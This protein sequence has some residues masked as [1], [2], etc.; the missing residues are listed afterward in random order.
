MFR[1]SDIKIWVRLTASIWTLLIVVW[2]GTIFWDSH[3]NR[4]VAI[5]Q[6]VDFSLSMYD[7]ALAGLTAM[8]I[9]ETMHKKHVLLD[10]IGHLAAIRELRVVPSDVALEGVESSKDA[11][12]PRNDLKP[13]EI[14]ARVISSGKE[15]VE[16]REDEKGP[17][18]LA[19]RPAK[20]V[21][22]Y[23]GRNCLECHDAAEN[24]TLGVIS[25]KIALDKM[26]TANK[27]QRMQSLG[28]ALLA[29]LVLLVFIW[30]FIRGAVTGPLERM[31]AGLRAIV[32][33]EG[34]LTRR[35]EVRG[36]DEIGVASAVFNEMMAKIAGLVRHVGESAAQVSSAAA[37]LV[38]R[39]DQVVASSQGQS[40]TSATTAQ[41]VEQMVA[42]IATVARSAEEVR[43]LSRESLRRSDEGNAS[44]TT[45]DERVGM[46]ET[47]VRGIA[48]SVGE[49][50]SSTTAI[51]HITSEVKELAEQT[52]LLALNAAIE[53]ARAGEQ[54]RGFA[55]VAD[56]VRKLAEKSASS[57]NEIDAI[58]H[59]LGKQSE[60]VTR[61][62]SDAMTHI[63]TSR[64][65]MMTVNGV[66]AAAS[67]SVV[68]VGRGLDSIAAATQEQE[69]V[70]ADVFSGIERIKQM[71]QGNSEAAG[72]T[73]AAARNMGEL[74]GEL[75]GAV[76]RFHT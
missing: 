4:K 11:G 25:I 3:N 70:S 14:E 22:K 63:A 34:D 44:L 60:Q 30:W 68:A 76:G 50:V 65:S 47:T 75:Q 29:S 33:G 66:L 57:A 45:L 28:I 19:V 5:E 17:Y 32:S 35:L 27:Q 18:L 56:E 43:Q 21:S 7:S 67:E 69:R 20:N 52:N 64:E 26:D 42:S 73:A 48:D 54:G 59:T 6:A 41:A 58:T 15:F 10:Q 16:V 71:A 39:A 31:V 13:N 9:T 38:V 1:F 40:A 24:A 12:K 2:A 51:T 62:I 53:A 23:L 49:F 8:M 37:E 61:S 72:Q 46:V 36:S 74:A 55:V